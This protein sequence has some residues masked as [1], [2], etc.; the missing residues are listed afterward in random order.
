[1][2]IGLL[3]F[4]YS[5]FTNKSNKYRSFLKSCQEIIAIP[6]IFVLQVLTNM[7]FFTCNQIKTID[8]YTIANEPIASINLM[9]RAAG[10]LSDWIVKRFQKEDPFK[11]FVGPGNNG[12]DGLALARILYKKG[13]SDVR[14]YLLWVSDKLSP[15]AE[16]NRKRLLSESQ[17]IIHTIESE[18]NFPA[19]DSRD[20]IVDGLFGSG[21][22]RPLSGLSANL[23]QYINGV[24][25]RAVISIDIPSGLFGEDNSGNTLSNVIKSDYTLSF[26]F[27][28]LSFFFAENAETVGH[29]QVLPIGLYPGFIKNEPTRFNYIREEDIIARLKPR[30]KFS[31]KGTYGHG[32]MIAG[33]YGMMGAAV[34]S[35]KAA[36]R[37]GAGLI[38]AHVP[39]CGVEIMQ[40][41]A[42]ES[43][44]STDKNKNFITDCP[45]LDRFSSIAVGPGL[46]KKEDTGKALM[47]L[48]TQCKVPV[49]IDADALNILSETE[50]W[51]NLIPQGCILTPHPKEFERLLGKFSD[52]YTRLR[53]QLNF[54]RE[55]K[56]I[57]IFKGAHT[58]ITTPDEQV[59]FNTS[60]NP[61]MATGGS[62]DV[63]TGLIMGLVAQGYSVTDASVIGVYIH[64]ASGD[65]AAGVNGQ[66]GMNASDIINN[67]GTVF[68]VL[69]NKKPLS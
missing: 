54:S 46:N 64:G 17:V 43:L 10:E 27:P 41:A 16:I 2:K 20:L 22:S 28:K 48:L 40:V 56:C 34:L 38:T 19:I 14:V 32:L 9:E 57:I 29:W 52:S 23:V 39:V 49:V 45:V 59:W 4:E 30:Q 63:L 11:I 21:L 1:L 53:A 37:S 25:K 42:P 47:K 67:I 6:V 50:D 35:T 36:L 5:I 24:Q 51:Q 7:K 61:G 12:G 8:A 69:E 66:Y 3:T 60:G 26:E 65:I 68:N 44:I 31:H 18:L 33:S 58:C 15:D 62:G 13:Y 55:K